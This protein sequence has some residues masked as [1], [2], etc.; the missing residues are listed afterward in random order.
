[1]K[2]IINGNHIEA[3]EGDS[4]L[5]AA[6]ASGIYIPHLCKHPDL[7]A[8][9]GC[10]LCSVEIEGAQEAVPSCMTMVSEGMVVRT[11]SE[12]ANATRKAAM[13]LILASHPAD[14]TGC[15]KEHKRPFFH[16]RSSKIQWKIF[17]G[18]T[19]K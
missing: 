9:G 11:D 4:V 16:Q 18:C 7:E 15:P 17:C 2:L 14:C 6:L 12:K 19:W 13:E 1:M 10:R 3:Q 5:E 8:V